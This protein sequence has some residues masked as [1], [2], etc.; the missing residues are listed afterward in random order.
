[1]LS[2][3]VYVAGDRLS[4]AELSAACLD[5]HVVGLG[6][7]YVPADLVESPALRAATL[8]DTLGA[9]LAASHLT[10]AWVHGGIDEP[11]ARL[12]VQRA[13]TARLHHITDRRLQYHDVQAD[14]EAL[15]RIGGCLVTSAERTVA[16]LA[17]MESP[18]HTAALTTW[19]ARDPAVVAAASAWL[20]SRHR[21]PYG[22]RARELL[23]S[24]TTS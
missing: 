24:L 23:G 7:A 11:P 3:F 18:E 8:A 20:D 19:A 14:P 10:A 2:R 13:V 12:S 9:S 17:R 6:D 21:L 1:M 22:R 15:E 4:V 5:G 16:D